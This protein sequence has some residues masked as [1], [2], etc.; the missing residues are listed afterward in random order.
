MYQELILLLSQTIHLRTYFPILSW[1]KITMH[2]I[3]MNFSKSKLSMSALAAKCT[4]NL[5]C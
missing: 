4:E 3:C 1:K 2:Q 5:F